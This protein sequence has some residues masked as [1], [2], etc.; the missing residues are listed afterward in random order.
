MPSINIG[1]D[2]RHP[3]PLMHAHR[4]TPVASFRAEPTPVSLKTLAPFPATKCA[5]R[6][7]F[8]G[9]LLC[10]FRFLMLSYCHLIAWGKTLLLPS[11]PVVAILSLPHPL[12]PPLPP[13]LT[14][15]CCA[16]RNTYMDT[17]NKYKYMVSK[18]HVFKVHIFKL[19]VL[20]FKITKIHIFKS[21]EV[22]NFFLGLT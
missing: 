21:I 6:L 8:G 17:E 13:L 18:I 14:G 12:P 16:H 15:H 19:H 5:C 22:S 3:P 7:R 20:Y 4:S 11:S 10:F 2:A 1:D 9:W